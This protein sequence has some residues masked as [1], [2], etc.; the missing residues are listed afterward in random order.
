MEDID[1]YNRISIINVKNKLGLK[2][3]YAKGD[4]IYVR[5]PF[6][7]ESNVGNLKLNVIKDSYYCRRCG[8]H[9]SAIGLYAKCNLITTKEAYINDVNLLLYDKIDEKI[10]VKAKIRYA[11]KEADATVYA[12]QDE[13]VLRVVF[14]IPQMAITPGQAIVFYV[15]DIVVGGGKIM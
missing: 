15:D 14:D 8:V 1:I 11:A 3:K 6:C 10:R 4:D 5:C 9:G 2:E 13:N 12:T 7:T